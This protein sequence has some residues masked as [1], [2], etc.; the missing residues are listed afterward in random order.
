MALMWCKPLIQ[1]QHSNL[2]TRAWI[3]LNNAHVQLSN[4]NGAIKNS[5]T[6]LFTVMK[7]RCAS[8]WKIYNASPL[9]YN[10]GWNY[11]EFLIQT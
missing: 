6:L 7:F 2:V 10:P 3:N 9:I 5:V 8:L 4:C 1:W 11:L